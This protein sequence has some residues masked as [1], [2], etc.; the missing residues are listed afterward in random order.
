M[1][2]ATHPKLV[3]MPNKKKH[4]KHNFNHDW[5]NHYVIES[6][7]NGVVDKHPEWVVS[8]ELGEWCIDL[9]AKLL[10]REIKKLLK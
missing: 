9:H 7:P 8:K 5:E 4:P 6:S 3:K 1:V 10:V 2:L